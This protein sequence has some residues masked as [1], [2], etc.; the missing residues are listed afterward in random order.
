MDPMGTTT[1]T[2]TGT[3]A[4]QIL[5]LPEAGEAM[6]ATVEAGQDLTST[7]GREVL[8]EELLA[9]EVE[10]ATLELEVATG[11]EDEGEEELPGMNPTNTNLNVAVNKMN[12]IGSSTA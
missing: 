5:T 3:A 1:E 12:V 7:E 2:I 10:A 4:T 8:K 6:E 11:E 9:A